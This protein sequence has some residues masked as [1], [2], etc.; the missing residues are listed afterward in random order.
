MPGRVL[1]H[2][3][4]WTGYGYWLPNDPRGSGSPAVQDSL[5][6]LG[7][8]HAGRKAQQPARTV[9]REFYE[10]ADEILKHPR[11]SFSDQHIQTIG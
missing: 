11:I 6:A 3:L 9:V 1:A 4:I 7:P 5:A 2:H 8:L 10:R